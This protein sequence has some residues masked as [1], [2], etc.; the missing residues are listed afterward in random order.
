MADKPRRPD[1]HTI[2]EFKPFVST[3]DGMLRVRLIQR[4]TKHEAELDIRW[5][6]KGDKG[7]GHGLAFPLSRIHDLHTLIGKIVEH[8]QSNRLS[9]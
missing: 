8:V 2:H 4:A 5:F 1:I 6:M 3:N 7:W 9:A